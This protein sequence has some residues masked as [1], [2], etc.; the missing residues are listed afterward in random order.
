MSSRASDWVEVDLVAQGYG[1]L[2]RC[3]SFAANPLV[4][5]Q[6][7][8]HLALTWM[9]RETGH[10]GWSQDHS[11]GK[12]TDALTEEGPVIDGDTIAHAN[13]DAFAA[14]PHE[15]AQVDAAVW[16]V[17]AMALT[18]AMGK[19]LRRFRRLPVVAAD[20]IRLDGIRLFADLS[21]A[22]VRLEWL[23]LLAARTGLTLTDGES[24]LKWLHG[25][26][27]LAPLIAHAT[28]AALSTQMGSEVA[29][30]AAVAKV[31]ADGTIDAA[32]RAAL[33][34]A[35]A[36]A[37]AAALAAAPPVRGAGQFDPTKRPNDY[38][39]AFVFRR[40]V[41]YTQADVDGS[42]AAVPPVVDEINVDGSAAAKVSLVNALAT[43]LQE[44]HS[45]T[46]DQLVA[47]AAIRRACVGIVLKT[48]AEKLD[49]SPPAMQTGV[50]DDEAE[51][52]DDGQLIMH[53]MELV[54][55]FKA[56]AAQPAAAVV[57][58]AAAAPAPP[59]AL[60][61]VMTLDA[62]SI[63]ALA[64]SR[65][66]SA[67][68]PG[69]ND[70]LNV[71]KCAV[72]AASDAYVRTG[73][74]ALFLRVRDE[75]EKVTIAARA[76][77]SDVFVLTRGLS[78]EATKLLAKVV[79][80]DDKT[81]EPRLGFLTELQ[82]RMATGALLATQLFFKKHS[83]KVFTGAAFADE[84]GKAKMTAFAAM[85]R[86]SLEDG[87]P[88]IINPLDGGP[89]TVWDFIKARCVYGDDPKAH[90]LRDLWGVIFCK[91]GEIFEAIAGTAT[92]MK[93]GTSAIVVF[94]AGSG[95]SDGVTEW[96]P[97]QIA[98]YVG[99]LLHK[100]Y[101]TEKLWRNGLSP[102]RLSLADVSEGVFMTNIRAKIHEFGISR[103]V[104]VETP[105]TELTFRPAAAPRT[106]GGDEGGSAAGKRKSQTDKADGDAERD[107]ET[108]ALKALRQTVSELK[109]QMKQAKKF[110]AGAGRGVGGA[111]DT[112]KGKGTGR[113]GGGKGE[114]I[115][116]KGAGRGGGKP[117]TERGRWGDELGVSA[118][119]DG[120]AR[121]HPGI[122][123]EMQV[124]AS[125]GPGP[126]KGICMH[127]LDGKKGCRSG[128]ALGGMGECGH[129]HGAHPDDKEAIEIALQE[130][131][132]MP[133]RPIICSEFFNA[134][135]IPSQPGWSAGG[136]KGAGRGG[137]KGGKG[138]GGKGKGGH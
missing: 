127:C 72:A 42:I 121:S 22:P 24:S 138:K 65:G 100:W 20:A 75:V 38:T 87:G 43:V 92:G 120:E 131:N 6:A 69:A 112:G 19:D 40:L 96:T 36:G 68:G 90:K 128:G 107:V 89:K 73:D 35:A 44:M 106:P 56:A 124:A 52:L 58:G 79:H 1:R 98:Y 97:Q 134:A 27:R 51:H 29:W 136:G 86:S 8:E 64:A 46:P 9:V 113:G 31:R 62:V 59:A 12:L 76:P 21:P 50:T 129:A 53:A 95:C 5:L 25:L 80:S 122:C 32:D 109:N 30:R 54:R 41:T 57:A 60:P 11:L 94:L 7:A 55:R 105:F 10:A 13:R 88:H 63:A 15:S 130:A 67:N 101:D 48:I 102:D 103:A 74:T 104:P 133:E 2:M 111:G 99:L 116:G 33:A 85:R 81:K 70:V 84:V 17:R 77:D 4:R 26:T 49:L 18:V 23:R 137:G 34:A 78:P 135:M 114:Q 47:Q 83:G 126:L 123:V 71:G 61:H 117:V 39:T 28:I 45:Y 82:E 14:I 108:P 37:G 16:E 118:R 93:A 110:D 3:I 115:G 125:N 132:G 91:W 119:K 66:G